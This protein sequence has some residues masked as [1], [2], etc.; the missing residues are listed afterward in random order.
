MV[1]P[2]SPPI[3]ART[4][5]TPGVHLLFLLTAPSPSSVSS[6]SLHVALPIFPCVPRAAARPRRW[7]GARRRSRGNGCSPRDRR[8]A[9]GQRSEEHTSELQSR[10]NLVCRL[11]LEKKKKDD[12]DTLDITNYARHT[13]IER[14]T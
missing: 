12:N 7:P 3:A 8:R 10:E 9:P 5:H 1:L 4:T 11:L 13:L 6:L 14:C 2:S